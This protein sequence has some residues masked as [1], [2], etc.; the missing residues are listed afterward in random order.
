M[1]I[2]A[3]NNPPSLTLQWKQAALSGWRTS[4]II[5]LESNSFILLR[6]KFIMQHCFAAKS[7]VE[8]YISK[9]VNI[10]LKY[11][12]CL[13]HEWQIKAMQGHFKTS[14]LDIPVQHKALQQPCND[15]YLWEA[16]RRSAFVDKVSEKLSL[17]QDVFANMRHE[18]FCGLGFW[19]SLQKV[20][21]TNSSVPQF[22]TRL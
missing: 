11:V 21:T 20:F 10:A 3:Q 9:H 5:D 13:L 19:W 22:T 2:S 15:S 7:S 8:A 18:L 16:L 14:L 12:I 4:S 1:E 6:R 17:H